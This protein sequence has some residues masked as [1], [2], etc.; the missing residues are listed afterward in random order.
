MYPYIT[1]IMPIKNEQD[2]IHR[3]LGAVLDQDYPTDRMEVLIVDGM[4]TDATYKIIR[5][6]IAGS[7]STRVRLLENKGRIVPTG[8]N[9]AIREARGDTPGV[10]ADRSL[11]RAPGA[12]SGR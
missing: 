7:G 1:V 2:C 9:L 4:S 11:R 12:Q 10:R 8:L 5:R 6:M 3:S